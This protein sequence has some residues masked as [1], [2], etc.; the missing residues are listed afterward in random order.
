MQVQLFE[1]HCGSLTQY[2]MKHMRVFANICNKKVSLS[3]MK[4]ACTT[5]CSRDSIAGGQ[6]ISLEGG[7]SS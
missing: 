6:Q 7:Y 2:G 3:A 1:A 4:D 5:V